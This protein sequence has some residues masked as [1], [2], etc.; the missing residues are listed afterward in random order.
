[1]K[2][3]KASCEA[4]STLDIPFNSSKKC[5]G[6]GFARSL[7]TNKI[8]M[9][10]FILF[11]IS[12]DFSW[13]KI[14]IF[15]S[16]APIRVSVSYNCC[17][18]WFAIREKEKNEEI[19]IIK[20]GTLCVYLSNVLYLKQAVL[21]AGEMSIIR[22]TVRARYALLPFWYTLFYEAELTGELAIHVGY[23]T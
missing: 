2:D 8:K 11:P 22:R 7:C 23:S 14:I 20:Y 10:W 3:L 5:M 1:M 13:L 16:Y 21:I 17:Q 12:H 15:S 18:W 6:T 9:S 19:N 4:S